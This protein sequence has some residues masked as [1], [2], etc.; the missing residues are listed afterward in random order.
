MIH[1]E[2]AAV[3]KSL[4]LRARKGVQPGGDPTT[5]GVGATSSQA[6]TWGRGITECSGSSGE[7]A[8]SSASYIKFPNVSKWK[9]KIDFSSALNDVQ[10]IK[11][12]LCSLNMSLYLGQNFPSTINASFPSSV[13]NYFK[14]I[15][16]LLEQVR[17]KLLMAQKRKKK[18]EWKWERET[19]WKEVEN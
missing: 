14:I 18:K 12:R 1:L 13:I 19:G 9:K 3:L 2:A 10:I 5:T 16:F 15:N 17:E 4:I 6:Q 7:S 11:I 8:D